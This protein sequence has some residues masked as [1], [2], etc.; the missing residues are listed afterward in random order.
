M[1]YSEFFSIP[2]YYKRVVQPINPSKYRMKSDKMMV[3]PLHD[4]VNPS[5]G[6]IRSKSGEELYHCF[7]CNKWGNIIDLHKRVSRVLFKRY[8][9]EEDSL[10]DLCRIFGVDYNLVSSKESEEVNEDIK[11]DVAINS[12]M[13]R[14]DISDFRSMMLDGKMRKKPIGYFNTIMIL[15]VSELKDK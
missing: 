4:D 2:E 15:A 14:F 6:I 5:M 3:C 9:T 1:N 13:E 12:A 10:K 7:G 8:L 11:V